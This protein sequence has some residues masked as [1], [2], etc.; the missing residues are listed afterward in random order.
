MAFSNGSVRHEIVHRT[1]LHTSAAYSGGRFAREFAKDKCSSSYIHEG[2]E[3]ACKLA[4]VV[5]SASICV[6]P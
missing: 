6:G 4:A 2:R 3:G 1:S 5:H